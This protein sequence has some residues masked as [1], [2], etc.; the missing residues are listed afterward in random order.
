[1]IIM[2]VFITHLDQNLMIKM[3]NI[4]QKTKKNNIDRK[5]PNVFDYFKSLSQETKD[6][7]DEIKDADDDTD[8]KKLLF[9]GS[10]KTKI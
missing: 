5:P 10:N 6:L 9:I 2:K 4:K 1:M 7:I 8:N 3:I